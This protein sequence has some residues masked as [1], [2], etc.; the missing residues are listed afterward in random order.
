MA[1]SPRTDL[2]EYARSLDCIHC[3]LC[4]DTC[5]TYR[6]TGRE[7]ASP[8]GRVHLM[9]GLGEGRVEPDGHLVDELDGCLLCRRCESVCPAGVRFGAMLEHSRDALEGV[10]RSSPWRDLQR[11]VGFRLLLPHRPL[12]GLVASLTRL[13]QATGL[14]RRLGPWIARVLPD[15][16]TLPPIPAAAERRR[17]PRTTP[18]APGSP[19][20]GLPPRVL[21]LEGCLMPILFGR[22]N[23][24]T[25]EAMATLGVQVDSPGP[26][27]CCGALHAHNGDLDEA[28][29][30]ALALLDALEEPEGDGPGAPVLV[31]SAGCGA[32]LKDLAEL[33]E[34]AD[35][36]H[37]RAT[38]LAERTVDLSELLAPA[39]EAG[40]GLDSATC[41]T[42]GSGSGSGS[43]LATALGLEP[44]ARIT[45]DDPCHLC[46]G[47]GLRA[48]PR[49]VLDA[50]LA[51]TG[52]ERIELHDSEGC[53]G[54]AGIYS[55]LEPEA[56][57]EI[58]DAKL[59]ELEK[60]ME[61][62]VRL[63]VTANPGCQLQWDQGIR[64]RGLD[65]RVMHLAEVLA[66]RLGRAT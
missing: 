39:L 13:G 36:A 38:A 28:R 17:L 16:R 47:Q 55:I 14:V 11:W 59:D 57:N 32:H 4:L 19:E 10:R 25:V 58:L 12:L 31:N 52:L 48:E 63:L 27:G 9:R 26:A 54:S 46:H 23:R 20:L 3:G 65:L 66:A 37:A 56:S 40:S 33:F 6:L 45:W 30:L 18:A 2:V 44:G 49:A 64:R 1:A 50:A 43:D 34:E 29:R 21:I 60:A 61:R 35:P 8:R 41:R 42:S 62:G 53:C 5:P 24:A 51:G 15:P 22:V 7:S